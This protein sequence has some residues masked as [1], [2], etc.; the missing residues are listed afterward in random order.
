MAVIG[1]TMMAGRRFPQGFPA[2]R[3]GCFWTGGMDDASAGIFGKGGEA[4]RSRERQCPGRSL[5]KEMP[6]PGLSGAAIL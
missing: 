6:V 2:V 3:F 4:R 5:R 1:I